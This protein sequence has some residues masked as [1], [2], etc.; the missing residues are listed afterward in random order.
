M[1]IH[2]HNLCTSRTH[3]VLQINL[4]KTLHGKFMKYITIFL[5]GCSSGCKHDCLFLFVGHAKYF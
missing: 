1:Y 5:L 4:G 2:Q 3:R